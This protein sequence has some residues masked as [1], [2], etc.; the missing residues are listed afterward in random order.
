MLLEFR[1]KRED[2]EEFVLGTPCL[3]CID[4]DVV[5]Y[6][7]CNNPSMSQYKEVYYRKETLEQK[8]N[9]EWI[10]VQ[11]PFDKYIEQSV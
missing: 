2:S 9:G 6:M 7:Q 11:L 8:I 4:G 1:A 3:D 5:T 10:S